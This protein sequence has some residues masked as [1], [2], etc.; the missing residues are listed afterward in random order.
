MPS[1]TLIERLHA[2]PPELYNEIYELTFTP[3]S[4]DIYVDEGYKP[5]AT[6]QVDRATRT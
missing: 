2:L 1:L 3:T 6:L 4:T 5:P